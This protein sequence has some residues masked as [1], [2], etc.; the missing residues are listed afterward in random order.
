MLALYVSS[1]I[2]GLVDGNSPW[3]TIGTRE[4]VDQAPHDLR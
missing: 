1:Q 3:A 2:D 4:E